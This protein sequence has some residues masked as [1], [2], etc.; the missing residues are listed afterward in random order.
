[1]CTI[2]VKSCPTRY[3][4]PFVVCCIYIFVFFTS[5]L[6]FMKCPF[7]LNLDSVQPNA[8]PP[9][10]DEQPDSVT[11]GHSNLVRC[12]HIFHKP[13]KLEH[14]IAKENKDSLCDVRHFRDTRVFLVML[15]TR[16]D[17]AV[18]DDSISNY[19]EKEKVFWEDRCKLCISLVVNIHIYTRVCYRLSNYNYIG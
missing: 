5:V 11:L 9:L 15:S 7:R 13:K 6:I 8:R 10:V 2:P 3:L 16:A 12:F 4:T 17:S 19:R 1:M 18:V 14:W